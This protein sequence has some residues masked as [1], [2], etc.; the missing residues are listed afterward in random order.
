MVIQGFGNVGSWVAREL[1]DR[2]VPVIAVS[3]V[4]G[5]IVRDSGLDVAALLTW[6]GAHRPLSEFSGGDHVTNDELL[7]LDCDVLVPA[8]LGEVIQR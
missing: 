4:T 8:A 2:G 3:D 7:E 1:H 5:G 6:V